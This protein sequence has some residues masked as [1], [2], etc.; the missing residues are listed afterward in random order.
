MLSGEAHSSFPEGP[1]HTLGGGVLSESAAAGELAV[2]P[3]R[4]LG[5]SLWDLTAS[6]PSALD[7]S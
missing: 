4:S 1:L 6:S 5:S 7:L 2:N 3:R